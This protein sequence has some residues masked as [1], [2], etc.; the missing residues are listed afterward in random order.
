MIKHCLPSQ[1][2]AEKSYLCNAASGYAVETVTVGASGQ[3]SLVSIHS[4]YI[5][6]D[7][8]L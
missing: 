2:F 1:C 5:Q 8:S 3:A 6:L 4:R 7:E